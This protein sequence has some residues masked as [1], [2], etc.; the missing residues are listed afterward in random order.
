VNRSTLRHNYG[1]KVTTR[2][3]PTDVHLVLCAPHVIAQR[4]AIQAATEA[5]RLAVIAT[6]ETARLAAEAAR[7]ADIA[8]SETER[9]AAA[10]FAR[11]IAKAPA[12]AIR[13]AALA[14]LESNSELLEDEEEEGVLQEEVTYVYSPE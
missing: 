13:T 11:Q 3:L 5:A 9:L 8:R 12:V 7:L 2:I 6:A 4:L 14:F 1:W 10:A